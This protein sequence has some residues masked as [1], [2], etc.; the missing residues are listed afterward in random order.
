MGQG[1]PFGDRHTVA[2]PAGPASAGRTGRGHGVFSPIYRV[3][4]ESSGRRPSRPRRPSTDRHRCR[5]RA[6]AGLGASRVSRA[7]RVDWLG[8]ARGARRS[9]VG[10]RRATSAPSS[11]GR[12]PDMSDTA[13][14]GSFCRNRAARNAAFARRLLSVRFDDVANGIAA[15][16]QRQQVIRVVEPLTHGPLQD[17]PLILGHSSQCRIDGR[18]L[19]ITLDRRGLSTQTCPRSQGL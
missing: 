15:G 7:L 3:V 11:S 5:N 17:P 4:F 9:R 12:W 8:S 13:R 19:E 2:S 16:G 18:C 6:G 1:D 10:G 14:Y